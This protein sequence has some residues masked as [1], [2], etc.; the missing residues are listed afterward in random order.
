M[1]NT[2]GEESVNPFAQILYH[3]MSL[4]A[5]ELVGELHIALRQSIASR[6]AWSHTSVCLPNI[7]DAPSLEPPARHFKSRTGAIEVRYWR[8]GSLYHFC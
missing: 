5:S 2:F 4:Q 1:S 8:I 7:T 3:G 6:V